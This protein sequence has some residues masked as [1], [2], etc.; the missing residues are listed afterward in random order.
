MTKTPKVKV[1]I[2]SEELRTLGRVRALMSLNDWYLRLSF[3]EA[4]HFRE[5]Y[6]RAYD[7]YWGIPRHQL[8]AFR[9]GKGK[10]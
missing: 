5:I 1:N 10:P 9:A 2:S 7:E 6:C 3:E 4:E 8:S